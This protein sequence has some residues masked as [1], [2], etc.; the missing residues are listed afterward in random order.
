MSAIVPTS[1]PQCKREFVEAILAKANLLDRSKKEVI[2]VGGRGYYLNS[3]GKPNV[4]DVGIYDDGCVVI[5]PTA[6]ATFNFNTDPG[7]IGWNRGI[8]KPYAVLKPGAYQYRKGMHKGQYWA[9]VEAGPV[10]VIRD[11]KDGVTK[12]YEE[13]SEDFGIHIHKGSYN[14]TSSEGCQTIYPDQWDA[15]KNL[16]YGE[17]DRHGQKVVTY[18]LVDWPQ[19]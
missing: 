8:G 11:P 18:L 19:S 2:I 5:S 7:K 15:M 9:F 12:A 10:T 1:N 6:Y 3:M 14:S 13:T 16:V 17:M 4:N